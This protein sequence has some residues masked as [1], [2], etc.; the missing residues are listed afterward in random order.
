MRHDGYYIIAKELVDTMHGYAIGH[1]K[2]NDAAPYAVFDIHAV[3]GVLVFSRPNY[4]VTET[5]ARLAYYGSLLD[6]WS[7]RASA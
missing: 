4:Y 7:Y 3:N 1:N 5:S 6:D 2:Y